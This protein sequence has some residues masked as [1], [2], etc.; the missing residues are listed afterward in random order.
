MMGNKSLPRSRA[1]DSFR[2]L[3]DPGLD[4]HNKKS[5]EANGI[6]SASEH[7]KK[8]L[9]EQIDVPEVKITYMSLYR[10]ATFGDIAII[11]FSAA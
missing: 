7:Q 1:R 9:E 11:F 2:T 4:V 5:I 6:D 8:V 10:F 3:Q